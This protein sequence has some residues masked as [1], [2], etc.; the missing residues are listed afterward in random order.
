[1][2]MGAVELPN[3]EEIDEHRKDT[4][5]KRVALTAAMYAVFLAIAALGGNN[6]TKE[7]LLAQQQASDLWAYYQA[8]SIREH[9]SR[10]QKL[11]LEADLIERRSEER[12][13]GKAGSS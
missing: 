11:R 10:V 2:R 6:A 4:F 5:T 8:K 7:M 1:F 3:P 13:V 9:Q 12:R